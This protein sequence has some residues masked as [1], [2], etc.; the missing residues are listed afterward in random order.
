MF[1]P[2]YY[3]HIISTC[4][5]I[6]YYSFICFMGV[7]LVKNIFDVGNIKCIYVIIS[8]THRCKLT[9]STCNIVGL[10]FTNKVGRLKKHV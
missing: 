2:S 5:T 1:S 4:I 6:Y 7:I 8:N 10:I 3:R 9:Q